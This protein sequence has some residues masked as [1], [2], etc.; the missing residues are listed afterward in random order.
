MA[1]YTDFAGTGGDAAGGAAGAATGNPIA[2]AAAV[3]GMAGQIWGG[4]ETARVQKEEAG[5]STEIAGYEEQI[6]KQKQ[7]QATLMYQR[8]SIENFR[9]AQKAS[10]MSRAAAVN[11]GAQ[12]GSG[13]AAGEKQAYGEAAFNQQNL[14]E[15]YMIGQKIFGLTS[16]IDQDQIR[17]AQLGGQASTFGGISAVGQGVASSSMALGRLTGGFGAQG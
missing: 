11:Q 8:Q 2:I 9:A 7:Q 14:A 17:L 4:I 6:N 15:N 3:A 16:S 5:I 1:S 10:H 13:A 12:F